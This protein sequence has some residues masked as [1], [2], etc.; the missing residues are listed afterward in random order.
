MRYTKYHGDRE[1]QL[2]SMRTKGWRVVTYK[3]V[4]VVIAFKPLGNEGKVEV[5]G[6]RGKADKPSFYYSFR[7]ESRARIY[8]DAF[9]KTYA[10]SLASKVTKRKARNEIKAADFWMVGDVAYNSW[11]YEQTNVDFYEVV[12]VKAKTV[13][14]RRIAQNNSDVRGG[15]FG[16]YTQPRRGEYAGEPFPKRV[17]EEGYLSFEF[18]SGAKWDG[19]PKYTSSYH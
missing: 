17:G 9:V 11:G 8:V 14:L 1:A 4:P 18:G 5:K 19:K 7:D 6:W 15:P 3:A 10:D 2:A 13:M 12:E 16:G